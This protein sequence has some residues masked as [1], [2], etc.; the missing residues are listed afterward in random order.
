MGPQVWSR[1]TITIALSEDVALMAEMGMKSYR[2][3][4][5]WARIWPDTSGVP[6]PDGVAFYR[7]LL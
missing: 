3:S 5:S 4:L 7:N 2:F 6:N 1:A